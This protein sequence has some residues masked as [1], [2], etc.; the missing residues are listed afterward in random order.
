MGM[1]DKDG[2]NFLHVAV[3]F[4]QVDLLMHIL[5]R[6]DVPSDVLN[7]IDHYGNTPLHLA[8]LGGNERLIL[9][10][11][12]DPRVIK[13]T[14]NAKGEKVLDAV[15]FYISTLKFCCF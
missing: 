4:E 3:K 7:G 1:V 10:L 5:D 15:S 12:Y 9:C 13:T 2:R 6:T 8:A 14:V 11:L